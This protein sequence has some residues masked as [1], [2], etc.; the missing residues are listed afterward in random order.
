MQSFYGRKLSRKIERSEIK[1]LENFQFFLKDENA[2]KLIES[3]NRKFEEI[4]LEIGFGSGENAAHQALKN[5]NELFLA[6]D[7]FLNGLI[8]LKKKIENKEINNLYMTNLDFAKFYKFIGRISFKK[9]FI[10]FPDPWPK[11]KHKKRRLINEEFVNLLSK[12]SAIGSKII[13]AT[14]DEDYVNQ[15]LYSFYLNKEF[16][17]SYRIRE[18]ELL[19]NFDICSTK[20]FLRAKKISKMAYFLLFE[21]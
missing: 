11:K 13:V 4:N 19:K 12:I 15:I 3:L 21:R 16:R 6:C 7:P 5:S 8:K 1:S 17:L 14:D 18:N 2:K 20:Y 9:V 10:L